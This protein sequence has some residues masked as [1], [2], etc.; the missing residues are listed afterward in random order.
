MFAYPWGH[1]ESSIKLTEL[2]KNVGKIVIVSN[3]QQLETI[4]VRVDWDFELSLKSSHSGIWYRSRGIIVT[5][6]HGGGIKLR[7]DTQLDIFSWWS[8]CG[9]LPSTPYRRFGVEVKMHEVINYN[10][11]VKCP[12]I[13]TYLRGKIVPPPHP[14]FQKLNPWP[15]SIREHSTL[16]TIPLRKQNYLHTHPSLEYTLASCTPSIVDTS[17]CF[18]IVIYS[19]VFL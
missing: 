3:G 10:L 4:V 1:H 6:W 8:I 18:D 17:S 19:S 13:K 15:S 9:H 2:H 12:L 7:L 14:H 11:V 16:Y 5:M